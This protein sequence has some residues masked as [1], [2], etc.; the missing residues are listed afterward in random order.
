MADKNTD[1]RIEVKQGVVGFFDVLGFQ[2]YIKNDPDIAS[3]SAL[4]VILKIKTEAP[5]KI[6]ARFH[7][8]LLDEITW[9][10]LSDT[11]VLSIP[12]SQKDDAGDAEEQTKQKRLR[13]LALLFSSVALMDHMFDQGL[14]IRGAISYGKY[15]VNEQSLA[16]KSIIDAL[17]LTQKINLSTVV[18][19]SEGEEE[20]RKLLN[21]ELFT[22]AMGKAPV[23]F[24]YLVPLKGGEMQKL[25]VLNQWALHDNYDNNDIPQLVAQAFW[26]HDKDIDADVFQKFQNTEMLLRYVVAM[27]RSWRS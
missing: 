20:M 5:E 10:V 2:N 25:L 1:V 13:W 3:R 12:Y 27:K 26:K 17:S 7:D 19:C 9:S 8:K 22:K 6:K 21:P 14:P 18:I 15:F 16:G 11:I 24:P 23:F 4:E